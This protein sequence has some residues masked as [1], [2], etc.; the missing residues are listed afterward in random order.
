VSL[1]GAG[2]GRWLTRGGSVDR[3]PIYAPDGEWVAFASNR[4]GNE[5]IWEVSTKTGAVRR[6]TDDPAPDFDPAYTRDGKHLIFSSKRSGHFE[7]WISD[8]DGSV[9]RRV[10]DD[11]LDAENA[12]ATPDGLGIVYASGNPDKRG[13]WKMRSDGT[14]ATLLVGGLAI[15]PEIS[16]DGRLVSYAGL[17]GQSS[18]IRAV[19]LED[20]AAVPFELEVPGADGNEL[21]HRFMPDGR[22]LLRLLDEGDGLF[23]LALQDF[24]PGR[25]AGSSRAVAGFKTD[26]PIESF[27]V[28][29]DGT[30]ATV[31]EFQSSTGLLL[32]VGVDDI[33]ARSD[34]K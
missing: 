5:D 12:S 2:P 25:A 20:G 13:I 9:P 21:R 22:A 26:S 33:V 7:I 32:A 4:S 15:L 24:V 19:R 27:G 31:S 10:S 11:G 28:S 6:L 18:V 29:P 1:T 34:S 3:Q 17:D 14:Q 16:P 30:R 8:R 23:G